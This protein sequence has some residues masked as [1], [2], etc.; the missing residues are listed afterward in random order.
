MAAWHRRPGCVD[1]RLVSPSKSLVELH[2]SR[3]S[4]L[5]F[6]AR[7]LRPSPGLQSGEFTGLAD[8]WPGLRIEAAQRAERARLTGLAGAAGLELLLPHVVGFP[9]TMAMLTH[10]AYPLPIWNALQIRNRLVLEERLEYGREHVLETR[11]AGH[12][13]LDKGA[14]IDLETQLTCGTR[15]VWRSEVTFFYRGRFGPAS[16]AHEPAQA[17]DIGAGAREVTFEMPRAGGLAMARMTGDY[18]P[19]HWWG[20]YARRLRF[21]TRFLHPQRTVGICMGRLPAPASGR[22]SLDLWIKGPVF[23]GAKVALRSEP[24]GA[25]VRFGLSVAGDPRH[26]IRGEWGAAEASR[27]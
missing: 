5:A 17:P 25:A 7:A 11:L 4:F 2:A 24:A 3:P 20:W 21:P 15:R 14:E 10:R 19:I 22:Q 9:L 13:I 1:S 6:A 16:T 8:R 27:E 12:R 26:A 18:N 23:Y